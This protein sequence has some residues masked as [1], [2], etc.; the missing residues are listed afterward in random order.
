MLWISV[1]NRC[2][3]QTRIKCCSGVA[4]LQAEQGLCR[5]L[6]RERE[7]ESEKA[8]ESQ[9]AREVVRE[10]LPVDSTIGGTVTQWLGNN[11]KKWKMLAFVMERRFS[12]SLKSIS[13]NV[14]HFG[15][16]KLCKTLVIWYTYQFTKTLILGFAPFF[17][18]NPCFTLVDEN[19]TGQH[20]PFL[21]CLLKLFLR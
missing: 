21:R 10:N 20:S 15:N 17:C 16:E 4:P 5:Q 18:A 1:Y 12:S 6:Q 13:G 3:D 2:T 9:R 11:F 14:N 7:P 8:R 19:D